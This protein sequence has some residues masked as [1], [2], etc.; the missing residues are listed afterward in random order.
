MKMQKRNRWVFVIAG[1]I[2]LLLAGVI[3]AW[4]VMSQ[5]ISASHP[6]WTATQLSITFTLAM[7]FFCT[8][9]LVVGL[10][11]KKLSPRIYVIL[12]AVLFLAGF[13]TASMTS[14][15]LWTLYV[16]FGVLCGLG[17]GFAYNIVLSTIS[18]W[19][20]DKQGL[21]SGILL[22]GF[23]LSSFLIGKIYTA[24]TPSD[25]SMGWCVTF[26]VIGVVIFAVIFLASFFFVR[27][28]E[29][30]V[31]PAPS[32]AKTVREPAADLTPGGMVRKGSFWL[33]YIWITMT[34]AAGM[35]LVSQ[36]SGIAL[37]VGPEISAGTIA[38]VVGMISILNAVGRVV[39]GALFD[40][41][42]FRLTMAVDILAFA[43][44]S[45]ILILTLRISSFPLVVVGFMVGGFAY[46]GP[47][48]I[49]SAFSSDFYGRTHYS[50]N[51]S[52]IIT[53]GI[54]ASFGS[55]IAG[56]LFDISQSYM[57]SAVMLLGITAVSFL[58]FIGI[59]RP[60]PESL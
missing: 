30:F 46:G 37:E 13:L 56:R 23:G 11:S 22:M 48:P 18:A 21:A 50:A 27:P 60:Q 10:L 42:G 41:R 34:G 3:Y 33:F 1:V 6:A 2:V 15:G 58:A 53:N 38:T 28:G 43:V 25:G 7:A 19:F 39:F 20:P 55:T 52:I 4:S 35:V 47:G 40:R 16:G 17:S 36:A 9:N 49:A 59:R 44:S 26:R 14:D 54:I 51:F 12:T 29:D 31:P 24:A 5:P 8:G 57:S 45:L 32:K